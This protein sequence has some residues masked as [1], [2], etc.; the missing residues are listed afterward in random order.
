MDSSSPVERDR[1]ALN[2][3]P[4]SLYADKGLLQSLAQFPPSGL[5]QSQT[6]SG[7]HY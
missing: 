4:A 5:S 3:V 1:A 7:H 2:A 6:D